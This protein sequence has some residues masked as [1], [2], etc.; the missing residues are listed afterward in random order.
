MVARRRE[1]A[2]RSARQD[3]RREPSRDFGKAG[4]RRPTASRHGVGRR[5][6]G[7]PWRSPSPLAPLRVSSP[8]T[9]SVLATSARSRCSRHHGRPDGPDPPCLVRPRTRGRR[10]SAPT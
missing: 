10:D 3:F 8:P 2:L 4:T 7:W 5:S 9:L 1:E 6:T